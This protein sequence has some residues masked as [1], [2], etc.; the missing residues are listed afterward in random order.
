MTARI[1]AAAA[2]NDTPRTRA[3]V[4]LGAIVLVSIF[5]AACSGPRSPEQAGRPS[6]VVTSQAFRD[7]GPIPVDFTCDGEN[8]SPPLSWTG[9]PDEAES[10]IV[11][12]DDP[13]APD[14]EEPEGVWVHWLLYNL[15]PTTTNLPRAVAPEDLPQGT[16][17]GRNDWGLTRYNGP[18]PI[19]GRHRIPHKVYALDTVLPD[20]EHPTKSKLI[21]AMRGHV[22]ARGR[23]TGTYERR[24]LA[25]STT[26]DEDTIEGGR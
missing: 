17:V 22:I 9:V 20:L 15:P 4:R 12:I 26:T 16:R 25:D 11:I 24:A 14:P 13:D 5:V 21:E 3:V 6:I 7:D 1:A 8:V 19:V 18:C 2:T 23:M 10:L